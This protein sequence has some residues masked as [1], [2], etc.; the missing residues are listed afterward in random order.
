MAKKISTTQKR[1][2]E[3]MTAF[4]IRPADGTQAQN[5][6]GTGIYSSIR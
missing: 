1:L 5:D 4:D 2:N 6:H 3:M